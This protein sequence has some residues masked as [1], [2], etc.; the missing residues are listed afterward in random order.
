MIANPNLVFDGYSNLVSGVDDGRRPNLLDKNQCAQAQNVIFRGGAPANRPP[1]T[2]VLLTFVNPTLTYAPNGVFVSDPG[3]PDAQSSINFKTALFQEASYYAPMEGEEHIMATIGGRLYKITPSLE[4]VSIREI[5]IPTR[6]R[7]DIP[8]NFHLQAGKFHI[9]QDGESSPIIFDGITA[10]RAVPTEI[11]TGKMMGYGQG[12]IVLVG[13]DN[14]IYFG[15][16]R[17]GM[18]NG[19]ADLLNFTETTFLNEGFPSALPS[20]MGN[21]TAIQFIPQQDTATGV[22]EC[23]VFG[24]HGVESFMLSLERSTW[25]NSAFQHTALLGI[26]APGHRCVTPVNEDIWF[27]SNDGYRSYRQARA[28]VNQYAQIPMSTNIRKWMDQD[29]P[30]LLEFAS[31]ISFNKRLIGTVTPYP[32]QGVVYHNGLVSL[33]FDILS[34]FGRLAAPAWDG[35]WT[36]R[37][38][39]PGVGVKV[40]QLVTGFFDGVERAFAFYLANG[41]NHIMEI[42]S[43]ATGQDTIINRTGK[44]I[45]NIVTRSMDFE[46]EFNE[47]LLYGGDCWIDEVEEDTDVTVTYRPDQLPFFLPWHNFSVSPLDLMQGGAPIL[48]QGFSPRRSLPKPGDAGDADATLRMYRRGYEF[49]I[50]LQWEGRA[51]MR[52]FRMHAQTQIEDPKAKIP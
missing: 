21:P 52:K 37:T 15:D 25:K 44:I 42:G 19:D 5:P 14:Q 26:G 30:A 17:D 49:Q 6:N 41:E 16:I 10:R 22:G 18:G 9:T 35:Q 33:D 51:A 45:S 20:G 40:L 43:V 39:D 13:K 3:G 24:Q 46:S 11:F 7:A 38:V 4:S 28:Q 47:K 29:T 27:R 8:I 50:G 12:R 48:A 34:T 2:N 32:N 31:C 23:L 1:F 36:D